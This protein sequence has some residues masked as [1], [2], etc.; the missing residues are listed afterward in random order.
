MIRARTRLGGMECDGY[1]GECVCRHACVP[2]RETV[3]VYVWLIKAL[4]VF[5]PLLCFCVWGQFGDAYCYSL[6]LS[7]VLILVFQVQVGGRKQEE[8][9]HCGGLAARVSHDAVH[10][11]GS[12]SCW[13]TKGTLGGE[14]HKKK[15]L[16]E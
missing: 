11:H 2:L 15:T 12:G 16:D 3:Y 10:L 13:R 9:A 14:G 4:C 1:D 8:S 7:L 6:S 5:G